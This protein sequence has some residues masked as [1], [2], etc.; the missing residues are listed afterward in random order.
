M[1]YFIKNKNGFFN[2]NGF[3]NNVTEAFPFTFMPV[4]H[5]KCLPPEQKVDLKIIANP[6]TDSEQ[7]ICI[8][9]N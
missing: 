2:F 8:K 1:A 7:E 3:T 4:N 9:N 5:V 6:G